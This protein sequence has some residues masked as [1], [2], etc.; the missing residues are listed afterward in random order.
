MINIKKMFYVIFPVLFC[1]YLF[2]CDDT[3]EEE[4]ALKTANEI[5]LKYNSRE[6]F[7]NDNYVDEEDKNRIKFYVDCLYEHYGKIEKYKIQSIE[8]EWPSIVDQ[9]RAMKHWNFAYCVLSVQFE[10]C[11][12]VI[13]IR[14]VKNISGHPAYRDKYKIY[15]IGQW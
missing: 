1:I 11:E 4:V 14:F 5:V 8:I 3:H 10:K 7:I 9:I 2:S 13:T 12:K 6:L 15:S